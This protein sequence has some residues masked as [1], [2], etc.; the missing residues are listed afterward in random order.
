MLT[1]ARW[2]NFSARADTSMALGQLPFAWVWAGPGPGLGLGLGLGRAWAG[3][4]PGPGSGAWVWGLDLGRGPGS[5]AWT[6]VGGLGLG[7]GFDPRWPRYETNGWPKRTEVMEKPPL[8]AGKPAAAVVGS[9]LAKLS[10]YVLA[11]LD[12]TTAPLCRWG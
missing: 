12:P 11:N 10:D 7:P 1:L 5:G 9:V 4:G 2:A 6:W 8:G 3:P